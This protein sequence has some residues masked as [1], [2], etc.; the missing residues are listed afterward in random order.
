MDTTDSTAFLKGRAVINLLGVT[1]WQTYFLRLLRRRRRARRFVEKIRLRATEEAL[2]RWTEEVRSQSCEP[3]FRVAYRTAVWQRMFRKVYSS[4]KGRAL[5]KAE[6]RRRELKYKKEP[7]ILMRYLAKRFRQRVE[8]HMLARQQDVIF[9]QVRLLEEI[10]E[11][12]ADLVTCS[13]F[14]RT[15]N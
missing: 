10:V 5:A 13:E 2:D 12:D 7:F 15:K 11:T 8:E 4:D 9:D 14:F 1:K 6:R 3:P